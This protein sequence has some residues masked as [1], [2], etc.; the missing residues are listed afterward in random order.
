MFISNLSYTY[1]TGVLV[2]GCLLIMEHY[3]VDPSHRKKMNVASYHLN[4]VIS[5]LL[6]GAATLDI[7]WI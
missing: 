1:L 2:S 6:L 5:V 4:Q 7:F 3:L